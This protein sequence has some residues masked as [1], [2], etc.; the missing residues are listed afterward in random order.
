MSHSAKNYYMILLV[1]LFTE[2]V[3]FY[4]IIADLCKTLLVIYK[5]VSTKVILFFLCL[6]CAFDRLLVHTAQMLALRL[7]WQVE[8]P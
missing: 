6:T 7:N 3:V 2:K 1:N 5:F 4:K 8:K